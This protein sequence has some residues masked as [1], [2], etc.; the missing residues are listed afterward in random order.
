MTTAMQKD[1]FGEAD[2]QGDLFGDAASQPKVWTP[3]PDKVRRR[4]ERILAEARAA[5]TMPWD[6]AQR[7][8]YKKIFPDMTRLLPESEG[9]QYRFQ[10]E[11]EWER[12]LA[13]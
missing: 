1:L 8:L 5:E 10:F 12:L 4:L 6:W 9:E 7:S 2:R 3:D 11:Q 13:A